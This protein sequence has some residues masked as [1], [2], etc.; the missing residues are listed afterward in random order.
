MIE[1][2]NT[3]EDMKRVLNVTDADIEAAVQWLNGKGP[4]FPLPKVFLRIQEEE[5]KHGY[6]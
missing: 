4:K 2:M 5:R 3:L 6:E 1:E